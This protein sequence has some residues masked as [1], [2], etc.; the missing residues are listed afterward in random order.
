MRVEIAA[1][2]DAATDQGGKLNILGAFDRIGGEL[3][4]VMPQCATAFRIRWD[5]EDAGEH[6]LSLLFEDLRGAPLLPPLESK[7]GVPSM[8]PEL[9][10]HAIN[11]V[12]NLQRLRVEHEG[13]YQMILRVDGKEVAVLPLW[14]Q[15]LTPHEPNPLA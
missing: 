1:I 9:D 8:P 6:S 2:C 10:S 5:R 4:M 7:I 11:L 15:D 13:K 12:L 14:V 3:P